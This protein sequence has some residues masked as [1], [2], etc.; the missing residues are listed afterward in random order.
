M[1]RKR[2]VREEIEDDEHGASA[3]ESAGNEYGGARM[4]SGVSRVESE[5]GKQMREV[6]DLTN[7]RSHQIRPLGSPNS[8]GSSNSSDG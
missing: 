8:G 5:K 4:D 7:A 3:S 2:F 6:K 1:A